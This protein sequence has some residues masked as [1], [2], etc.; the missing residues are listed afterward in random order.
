MLVCAVEILSDLCNIFWVEES[1]FDQV[2]SSISAD[3][4]NITIQNRMND[5]CSRHHVRSMKCINKCK[6]GYYHHAYGIANFM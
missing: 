4:Q 6:V 1:G 5:Q 2:D 3:I